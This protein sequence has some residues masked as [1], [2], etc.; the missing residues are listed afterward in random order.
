MIKANVLTFYALRFMMN[1]R[2]EFLAFLVVAA[3]VVIFPASV[4]GYERIVR[5]RSYGPV[6]TFDLVA[7]MPEGGGWAP[8]YLKVNKGDWVRLRLHG[9]D[10]VHGFAIGKLPLE[11][12][13]V[14]PGEVAEVEFSTD[15]AGEFTYYCNVWCS[16]NHWRMR[17][18]LE[19]VDPA[20]GPAG[21]QKTE[22]Q[23]QF[24]AL[25]LDVDAPH[26]AAFVPVGR[27]DASRG[28]EVARQ[29]ELDLGTWASREQLLG[30]SPSAVFERLRREQPALSDDQVW[31]LVAYA[32][33]QVT[34]PEALA[35]GRKLYTRNCAACHGETGAGDGPGGKALVA[36]RHQ[37][38]A[39][40]MQESAGRD[41]A[42]M[43]KP[44]ANFR[45]ARTMLGGTSWIY[46]GKLMRGGMGTGM[47]YF[48][49]IFTDAEA[50]AVI[51]YLWTFQFDYG[52]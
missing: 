7:R 3:I 21:S 18:V 20:G 50:W 22:S 23:R 47:P 14:K 33:R 52:P 12:V 32:W 34:T 9:Q 39:A 49:P 24:E 8:D 27:P 37:A 13:T 51:D 44:P 15:Q 10:V 36:A 17:G 42:A 5:P 25:K 43:D 29:T 41:M 45:D 31:D 19:V 40:T 6:K 48:G 35:L 38:S 30:Q 26:D 28:A 1:Q 46:Y 16:P 4:F 11:P 2:R